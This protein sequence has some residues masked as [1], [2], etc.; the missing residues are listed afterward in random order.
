MSAVASPVTGKPYGRAAIRRVWRVA[1]SGVYR[2]RAPPPSTP[3]RRRGP[4]GA[5]SDDP[6]IR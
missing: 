5:M 1:R 2:H 6:M 3:P 4:S